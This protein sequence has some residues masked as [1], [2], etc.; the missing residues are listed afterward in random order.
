MEALLAPK[1]VF[2]KTYL[3]KPTIGVLS[4]LWMQTAATQVGQRL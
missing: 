2:Y 1:G 4:I 3:M